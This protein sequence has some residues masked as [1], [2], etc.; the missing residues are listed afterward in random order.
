MGIYL[1]TFTLSRATK[2]VILLMSSEDFNI[3]CVIFS[4]IKLLLLLN[5]PL[6]MGSEHHLVLYTPLWSQPAVSS[7][8]MIDMLMTM[9]MCYS[10]VLSSTEQCWPH[11]TSNQS[12]PSPDSAE[13]GQQDTDQTC[14]GCQTAENC[15]CYR[16]LGGVQK[17]G[18]QGQWEEMLWVVC[19]SFLVPWRWNFDWRIDL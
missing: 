7:D 17:D 4:I 5:F 9:M 19:V 10:K 1:L 18:A 3:C 14:Y 13:T 16:W 15:S 2:W 11:P 12:S 6:F 8:A